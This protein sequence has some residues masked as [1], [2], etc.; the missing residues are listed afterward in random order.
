MRKS[1]CR[2]YRLYS[3]LRVVTGGADVLKII[4]RV[5]SR[6]RSQNG[7]NNQGTLSP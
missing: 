5:R 6:S 4:S 2:V 7:K 3:D 1:V